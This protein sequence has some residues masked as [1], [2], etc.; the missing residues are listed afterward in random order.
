MWSGAIGTH[1]NELNY[2]DTFKMSRTIGT[3]IY[4]D[5]NYRDTFKLRPTIGTHFYEVS[6]IGTHPIRSVPSGH[7][8]ESDNYRD[9][10]ELLSI[11]Y[12]P[13]DFA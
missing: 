6:S 1:F 11:F 13:S 10:S 12:P 5:M 9:T 3:H 4:I 8:L 7:I 2:R